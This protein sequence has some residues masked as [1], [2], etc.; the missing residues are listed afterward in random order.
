MSAKRNSERSSAKESFTI[1]V[2]ALSI[3]IERSSFDSLY[4]YFNADSCS[5]GIVRI[6]SLVSED[7]NELVKIE[8]FAAAAWLNDFDKSTETDG[9]NKNKLNF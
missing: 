9:L 6:F 1:S 2:M 3:K 7:K 8:S 4:W 5:K